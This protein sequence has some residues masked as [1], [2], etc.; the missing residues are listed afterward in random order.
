MDTC[1]GLVPEALARRLAARGYRTLTP[2][3]RAVLLADPRADLLVSAPTGSGKTVAFG[4]AL[5]PHLDGVGGPRALVVTPTRELA[6]QVR[7]ELAGLYAR[8]GACTGGSGVEAER[9]ALAAGLD[10]VVGSPGRLRDHIARGSLATGDI[11]AVVLDEADVML[12]LG[13]RDD[14]EAILAALPATRRTLMFSATLTPAAEA[15]AQRFQRDALRLDLGAG[16]DVA[17]QAVAVA[18]GDREAA[19]A[20]LLLLHEARGALVFCGRREAVGELAGRLVRRGFAV[21]TLSGVLSQLRRNAA[22]AAM[23]EGR[24]RVCVATDLA[25]RGIDLPG[26][27]LV[28]HADLPAS[29][30]L[31][32]HRSG[33]TGRAGRPGLAVLI[34]PLSQRRRAEALIA[35]AGVAVDW[36]PP[37]DRAEVL[38]R[39]LERM[40][41]DPALAPGPDE[42]GVA[43]RLLAA[44][45]PERVA[46]A[47]GR[48]WAAGRP[49]PAVLGLRPRRVA[50]VWLAA[51]L[52][53]GAGRVL[54]LLCRI[55]QVSRRDIG[56]IRVLDA[57]TQ[58]E[59]RRAA[60]RGFLAAARKSDVEVRRLDDPPGC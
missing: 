47:F 38:A 34:V 60:A 45:G 48:L 26:L 29:P 51:K 50:G 1:R 57:E 53:A 52:G 30:E 59:I 23:R 6:M 49:A 46:A 21:V 42:A 13:F 12:D 8:V 43:G 18:P 5:A 39:E 10:V 36:T 32:L 2:V 37:P 11:A 3:Q 41:A 22:L 4:L 19:I 55:G 56:R 20:N 7:A 35:G 15:L 58:F 25:A 33:R 16:A 17:Y 40:L 44:H 27:E 28:L 9:A 14:L 54:P 31:L 24:A